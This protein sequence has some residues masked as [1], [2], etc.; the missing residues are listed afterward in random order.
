[1]AVGNIYETDH[2]N[3]ILAAGRA[4]LVML[5]RP[6]LMDASWTIRSAAE[7]AYQGDAVTVPKQYQTAYIQLETNLKRAAE[8]ILNA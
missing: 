2:V 1:M 3:S 4:D 6:H 5:A 8:M 7:L